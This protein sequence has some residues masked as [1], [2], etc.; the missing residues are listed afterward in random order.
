M[1]VRVLLIFALF[2]TLNIGCAPKE[3]P[4]KS[5]VSPGCTIRTEVDERR[6]YSTT[7]TEENH[8]GNGLDVNIWLNQYGDDKNLNLVVIYRGLDWLF[9]EPS[10]TVTLMVDEERMEL[11]GAG[12]LERSSALSRWWVMEMASYDITPEQLKRIV[13]AREVTC[14]VE[15]REY[16]FS[17]L[18]LACF[19]RFYEKHVVGIEFDEDRVR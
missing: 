8:L 18:N 19:R 7:R 5:H 1:R 16:S 13:Y 2:L 11:S 15:N 14:T 17:T 3:Y 6:S 12:S 4:V 10:T 9:V